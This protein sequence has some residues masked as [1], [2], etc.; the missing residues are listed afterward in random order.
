MTR[1]YVTFSI[2]G[3]L[4][5][6]QV[7][8]VEETLGHLN[9]TPVPLAPKG[10]A[11]LVNLRGQVVTTIDLRP[12]LGLEPLGPKD[13]SMMIVIDVEGESISLLVDSVGEVLSLSQDTFEPAPPTLT[14]EMRALVTGAFKLDSTLLLALDVSAVLAA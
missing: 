11:G 2:A 8:R 3:A 1:Q 7:L 12:K 6:L 14:D 4:Y 9:R 10:I 13:E 5:G